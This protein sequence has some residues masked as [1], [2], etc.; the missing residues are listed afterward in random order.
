MGETLEI[1]GLIDVSEFLRMQYERTQEELVL[2]LWKYAINEEWDKLI[3]MGLHRYEVMPFAF[4]FFSDVPDNMKYNFAVQAYTHHGDSIPAVRKAVRK[5]LRYGKPELP[6]E[7]A[8]QEE[9]TVYRAGEEPIDKAK[10]RISWT[11]DIE[12]AK[13]F[14]NE[15]IHKHAKYLYKGK[16]K[17]SKIIAYTD[18][19]GEREIMQYRNVYDIELIAEI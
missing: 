19:R 13:F 7:I 11:S 1:N 5:A 6:T 15:Y 10:Y 12:V 18:V 17:P 14:L 8:E 9:I 16:I 4:S 2:K 3:D